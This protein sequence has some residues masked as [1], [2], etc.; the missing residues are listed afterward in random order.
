VIGLSNEITHP[1]YSA[2]IGV[3]KIGIMEREKIKKM[4]KKS[5][6]RKLIDFLEK[7]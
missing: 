7:I 2:A 1:S 4:K 6:F 3:L 5:F